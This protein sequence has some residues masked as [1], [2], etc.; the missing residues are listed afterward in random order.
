M[1]YFDV[2]LLYFE[3]PLVSITFYTINFSF[4]F[5]VSHI[6][7]STYNSRNSFILLNEHPVKDALKSTIVEFLLYYLTNYSTVKSGVSTIVE[8]LLYYLTYIVQ[9]GAFSS[10]IVEIL[11]YYLT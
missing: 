7:V 8:I 3:S 4:C 11:L 2:T 6:R 10:T 1:S 9:A 5:N